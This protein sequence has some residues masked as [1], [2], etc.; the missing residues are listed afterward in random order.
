MKKLNAILEIGTE[1]IPARFVRELLEDL[2]KK[3]EEKLAAN[4][5]EY[6]S[7]R[8]LGTYRRLTLYIEGIAPKQAD[9]SFEVKGPPKEAAFDQKGWPTQAG[10]GF[11]KSRGVAV[12]DLI[13]KTEGT[14]EYVFARVFQKGL[15]TEKI[16]QILFP[17]IITSLYLP[18]SMR[19]G[20]GDF[21]FIRPIHWFLA[22]IGKKTIGFS[23]AGI[24]SSN[25]TFGHRYLKP[26][27]IVFGSKPIDLV[28]YLKAL[29]SKG[30]MVNYDERRLKIRSLV[31]ALGEKFKGKTIVEEELLEEVTFLI[32]CPSFVVGKINPDFLKLPSAVL[33]TSLKKNQKAFPV[34]GPDGKLLPL[35][36]VVVDSTRA[37]PVARGNERVVAA[38]LTDAA[39][40]FE[41]DKEVP[42]A[43]RITKLQHIAFMKDLGN[44]FDK[45]ERVKKIVGWLAV[46]LKINHGIE[47]DLLR[48][49]DLY[50]TDL[51]TKMVFEFTSL[52]GVMGKEYALLNGEK[53]EVAEAIYE[54]YL[55]RFTGDALPATKVGIVLSLAERFD[56]LVG[57]FA[58]GQIP[59]GS[60]DPY[61]LRRMAQGLVQ[62]V[63]AE[64][65]ELDL[66]ELF[67]KTY[68]L[69]EALLKGNKKVEKN[70]GQG[71]RPELGRRLVPCRESLFEFIKLRLK[72]VLLEDG[73]RH[74]VVEACLGNFNQICDAYEKARIVNGVVGDDWFKGVFQSADRVIRLAVNAKRENVITQDLVDPEEKKLHELYLKVNWEVEERINKEDFKGALE[75]LAQLTDPLEEFFNKVMVMC[76]DE[77]LKTNRLALLKTLERM[78]QNLLDFTKFAI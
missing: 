14:K 50:K 63:L 59:S 55:P 9:R 16:L 15:S 39:F 17:E 30:V 34:A 19:W 67:E 77:R 32:E 74:D 76:E 65:L 73:Y 35:F 49:A 37:L 11:A 8:T 28:T 23:L 7:V 56:S 75:V 68:K 29:K 42:L 38:R 41:E 52:Q 51:T 3:A 40:F 10:I 45:K 25:K 21:K 36:I 5:I 43:H 62:I 58:I 44:M 20:D 64:K 69:Y 26:N 48:A 61:G 4:C 33:I 47:A 46:H 54:H 22:L 71:P 6:S 27:Q 60:A 66:E 31:E 2:K 57:S 1:E 53:K 12:K 24:K 13:V 18:L 78:Y 72:N 70:V